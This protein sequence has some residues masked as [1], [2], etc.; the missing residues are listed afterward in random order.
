[1]ESVSLDILEL[2]LARLPVK[3]LLRFKSVSASWN[4]IISDKD[5]AI[6]HFRQSKNSS[7]S[8]YQHM[9]LFLSRP[10]KAFRLSK[11]EDDGLKPLSNDLEYCSD[12]GCHLEIGQCCDGLILV[13]SNIH[14]HYSIILWNPSARKNINLGFPFQSPCNFAY[15]ITFDKMSKDYKIVVADMK[16]KQYAV[17][18]NISHR[19]KELRSI[20]EI[21][22]EDDIK[23]FRLDDHMICLSKRVKDQR[24]SETYDIEMIFFDT[25]DDKFY[26]FRYNTGASVENTYC[27]VDCSPSQFCMIIGDI[28][29]DTCRVMV[30]KT[31][32]E[33]MEFDGLRI[34]WV[35]LCEWRCKMYLNDNGS[36][37]IVISHGHFI[38]YNLIEGKSSM[39]LKPDDSIGE[40]PLLGYSDNL[41]FSGF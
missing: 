3:S 19:W 34:P 36:E 41:F 13:S 14:G 31:D 30:K 16:A 22:I 26:K 20:V 11:L 15:G 25:R 12:P 39:I 2:I 28:D 24:E 17:F 4:D 23:N 40:Y 7:S 37:L 1:M 38:V 35:M 21:T 8:F 33:W 29:S 10:E 9:F 18:D 27:L 5:F 32:K 6:A